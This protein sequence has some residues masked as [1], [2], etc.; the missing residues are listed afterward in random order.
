[1][2]IPALV[3]IILLTNTL[4]TGVYNI[5]LCCMN[6][7]ASICLQFVLKCL[8]LMCHHGYHPQGLL[9]L[10]ERSKIHRDIKVRQ[11]H[12]MMSCDPWLM[13]G[14]NIL[15]TSDGDVKLGEWTSIITTP[16]YI[17]YV[18]HSIHYVDIAVVNGTVKYNILSEHT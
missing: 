1:M 11:Q 6:C 18:Y 17:T 14:A 3:R 12:H 2:F 9:Y 7:M 15:L 13:Q 4:D 10:H 8:L 5:V 16:T